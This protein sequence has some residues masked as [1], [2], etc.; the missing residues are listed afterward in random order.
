MEETQ[1]TP[2]AEVIADYVADTLHIDPSYVWVTQI[3]IVIFL[4]LLASY[5]V[6]RVLK[7]VRRRLERTRTMWDDTLVEA[8][9]KPAR[10]VVW[11][12]GLCYAMDIVYKETGAEIFS[13]VDALR[14]VAVI[15]VLAWWL[16]RFVNAFESNIVAHREMKGD[17]VDHTTVAAVS[18]LVRASVLITAGLVM[19]QT[20]GFSIGGVLAFGGVGG[21]AVGFAAK[22]ILANFFG[23]MT[24]YFD[25]PFS[26]G[27]WIRSP[28]KQIE[29]VVEHIGWR[30][31]RI[32]T[33]DRRPLYVPNSHFTTIS[34][35]NPSRMTHRRIYENIGIRHED[36][37][38]MHAITDDVRAMLHA[39]PDIDGSQLLMV[40]F[41]EFNPSSVDFMVYC[42]TH[43]TVW[44]E[45]HKA[46]HDVL[47]KI[48]EIIASHGAQLAT[49][50]Q[51]LH[52]PEEMFAPEAK[53]AAARK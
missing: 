5:T 3:F 34:V 17:P 27:D 13:G 12:I 18:K 24:I 43:T 15:A 22:D 33:F 53:K 47:L 46:K 52:V 35:E 10:T 8:A 45:F 48:A 1:E 9:R 44:T 41:N 31:T 39:H 36:I 16:L 50:A 11:V 4:T 37:G 2:T 7:R 19:L 29:G 40:H 20:L 38:V 28:D 32:R 21:I 30:Q 26:V 51:R 23:A 6:N 14:S 25:R 49:P 42:F